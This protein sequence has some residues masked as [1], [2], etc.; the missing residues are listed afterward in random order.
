MKTY[1]KTINIQSINA[2]EILMDEISDSFAKEHIEKWINAWNNKDLKKSYL[3][4]QKIFD[5]TVLK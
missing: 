1:R 5:S 4:F 2:N 3:C